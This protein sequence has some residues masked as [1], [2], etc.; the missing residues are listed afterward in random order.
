M[1]AAKI[2][3][4]FEASRF[5]QQQQKP[6]PMD[7]DLDND[8]D[9]AEAKVTKISTLIGGFSSLEGGSKTAKKS[10]SSKGEIANLMGF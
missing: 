4:G 10:T 9:D 7:E 6:A 8:V 5:K 1:T 2:G 3:P